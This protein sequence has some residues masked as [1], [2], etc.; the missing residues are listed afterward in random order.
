MSSPAL[1]LHH[2][3]GSPFAEKVRLVLGLKGL[4]WSSVIIPNVMPKP[5]YTPLTG[6]YRRTPALQIGADIYCDTR[7]I[8]DLLESLVPEPSVY[9]DR[10]AGLCNALTTWAEDQFFWPLA[11]YITGINAEHM[12]SNFHRDRAAMRGKDAPDL[13]RVKRAALRNL[14]EM[15]IHFEWLDSMLR[16]ADSFLLGNR[17]TL[18][19]IAVYHGLWFLGSKPD[20]GLDLIAPYPAIRAWMARV[21]AIGHGRHTAMTGG[22]ALEIARCAEPVDAAPSIADADA[23]A[24]GSR[25]TIRATDY[26]PDPVEGEL[27]HV[28]PNQ[29]SLLRDAGVDLGRI[30]VH[31]PRQQYLLKPASRSH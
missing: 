3:D 29:V 28:G 10:P 13:E 15:R 11:R 16:G 6:G 23:P 5:L 21:A 17:V 2:Y 7:L 31:F 8:V 24:L 9:A 1:I 27:V 26:G 18:A 25:V 22:E 14:P 4:A 12:G 30:A 20:N 19:D